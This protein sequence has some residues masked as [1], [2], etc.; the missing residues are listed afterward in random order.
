MITRSARRPVTA[1]STPTA[2]YSPPC[3]GF[4]LAC[5]LDVRREVDPER[6]RMFVDDVAHAPAEAF[7]QFRGV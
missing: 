1:P 7:G 5:S 6:C 3:C 2:K 4:P